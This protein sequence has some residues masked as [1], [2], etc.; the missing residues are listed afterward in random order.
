MNT[1]I[2]IKTNVSLTCVYETSLSEKEFNFAFKDFEDWK[3]ALIETFPNLK[4]YKCVSECFKGT[5]WLRFYNI[6]T[7]FEI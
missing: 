1:P 4:Q 2:Y 5:C 3:E 7:S 6:Q